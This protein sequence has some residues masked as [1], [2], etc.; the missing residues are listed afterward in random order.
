MGA[1]AGQYAQIFH[2]FGKGLGRDRR[3]DGIAFGNG[4]LCLYTTELACFAEG[5]PYEDA[6][7][8][9]VDLARDEH[10]VCICHRQNF[11][12]SWR[13][14]WKL[15]GQVQ[16]ASGVRRT[17]GHRRHLRIGMH[18]AIGRN[19][20]ESDL[21]HSA[22]GS[23]VSRRLGSH[24]WRQSGQQRGQ[25]VS[26]VKLSTRRAPMDQPTWW[27]GTAHYLPAR[28]GVDCDVSGL[29]LIGRARP[30]HGKPGRLG[31]VFNYDRLTLV[32]S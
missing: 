13:T 11:R 19:S 21:C 15:S 27:I 8:F 32:L 10:C 18:D 23:C 31:R 14:D 12:R 29:S 16:S 20:A 25:S 7:G 2:A 4:K 3:A 5:Y 30:M 28:T 9:R 26:V 24:A 17:G 22:R 6:C 1:S